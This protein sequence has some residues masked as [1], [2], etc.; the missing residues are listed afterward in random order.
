M[1]LISL[2]GKQKQKKTALNSKFFI[3]QLGV[4]HQSR[5]EPEAVRLVSSFRCAERHSRGSVSAFRGPT[6]QLSTMPIRPDT[7]YWF[8][9]SP[10]GVSGICAA[11]PLFP[12]AVLSFGLER[13]DSWPPFGDLTLPS[14]HVPTWRQEFKSQPLKMEWF[15]QRQ[16]ILFPH[17]S[18][19]LLFFFCFFLSFVLRK[20]QTHVHVQ[21]C[22][23]NHQLCTEARP[24][25]HGGDGWVPAINPAH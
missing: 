21:P 20:W 5:N 1:A 11:I 17:S 15:L 19:I 10:V 16:H 13:R 7:F 14:C 24:G 25:R 3:R 2:I 6:D 8:A 18:V 23:T 22:R 9:P 12:W 4:G